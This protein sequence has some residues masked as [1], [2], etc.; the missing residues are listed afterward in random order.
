MQISGWGKPTDDAGGISPVLRDA[1]VDTITNTACAL[2]FPINVDHRNI[3]ISG[4]D[5][6]STCNVGCIVPYNYKLYQYLLTQ[7]D[8][9]GPLEYLYED[10]KYRQIGITSF[11]SALG[12]EIGM[13]AAF[14]R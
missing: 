2:Q 5:G 4:K 14:T 12:C 10:G 1:T 13:H 7:G 6:T 8:S 3:C 9:G 11:G